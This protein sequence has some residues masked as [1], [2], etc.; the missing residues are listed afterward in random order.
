M[1]V[2]EILQLSKQSFAQ[3]TCSNSCVFSKSKALDFSAAL[4][5]GGT[6]W[7]QVRCERRSGTADGYFNRAHGEEEELWNDYQVLVHVSGRVNECL[8]S[9]AVTPQSPP[10][11][12]VLLA[13]QSSPG[14]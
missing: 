7:I 3:I 14:D 2:A 13:N 12:V 5:N 8:D 6:M 10:F 4:C 1:Y 11:P 9:T